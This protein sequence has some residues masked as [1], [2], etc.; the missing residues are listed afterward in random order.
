[1]LAFVVSL[2]MASFDPSILTVPVVHAEQIQL[3]P[4]LLSVCGCESTGDPSSPPR[5]FNDDGSVLRGKENPKDIGMCQINEYWNGEEA[6]KLGFDIYTE[7]GNI[8][9][10]N[11][12]FET[13]GFKPWG[14]S[15]SC[16]RVLDA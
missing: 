6:K 9:M 12:L 15:R 13:R 4:K 1:M 10:A 16:W 11:Y 8:K 7:E 5:Q 3:N 2:M 14:A